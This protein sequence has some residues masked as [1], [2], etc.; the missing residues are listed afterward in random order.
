MAPDGHDTKG[1]ELPAGASLCHGQYTI[2]NYLN[3]GGFGVTYLARDSLG[4]RI[5][6]KECFPSAMCFRSNQ[7][8][9]VRS[10]GNTIEFSTILDLFEKEARA[11]AAMQHPYIVGVHQYFRDN[12]T[13]YMAMDF[14]EGET[15]LDI[16]ETDPGR[17]TPDFV[18]KLLTQLL[19][20]VRYI[21]RND[22][23]HRDISPDNILIDEG[24][25]PVLIDFGAA[26]E[27]A[28]KVSRVLSQVLTVKDGYSPQEF[29][30]A[31]SQQGYA[32]DLYALAATFYH[33]IMR[34]APANSHTRLAAAARER[35]DPL[36]E[37]PQIEGYEPG[38][39][40]AV[41]QCLSLFPKDRLQSAEAWQEAIDEDVRQKKLLHEAACDQAIDRSVAALVKDFFTDFKPKSS[42][43]S[44]P[45]ASEGQFN[46]S[47]ATSARSAQVPPA[48]GPFDEAFYDDMEIEETETP[49]AEPCPDFIGPPA[50]ILSPIDRVRLKH[51]RPKPKEPEPPAANGWLPLLSRRFLVGDDTSEESV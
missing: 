12:G 5:V 46:G 28:T 36:S 16:I 49:K 34:E 44:K 50:P 6:I 27:D 1:D 47:K 26:R 32:S 23:L 15:L 4:R 21:H 3:A 17:L 37:L 45:K 42:E 31:G 33:A 11:L 8:V 25:L 10:Q 22:I 48:P 13:A 30:L 40:A 43:R 39:L 35:P 19:H 2:E 14:V 29:Y 20:A 38:F 41:S 24:G 9:C 51:A 7:T 18:K